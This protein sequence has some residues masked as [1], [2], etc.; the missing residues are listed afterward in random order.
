M[1]SRVHHSFVTSDP[2]YRLGHV[3]DLRYVVLLLGGHKL[4]SHTGFWTARTPSRRQASL[5]EFCELYDIVEF[6]SNIIE[7]PQV[8]F[9]QF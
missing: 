5:V 7:P 6:P 8:T 3:P 9:N 1:T 4:R 2:R